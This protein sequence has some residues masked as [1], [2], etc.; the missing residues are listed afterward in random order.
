M[1]PKRVRVAGSSARQNIFLSPICAE[2]FKLI[3]EK[4]V[5][6]ERSINFPDITFLPEMEATARHY[7]WMDFNSLIGDCNISWVREFY[8]NAVAYS[9]EDFTSTVRGVR[10]SYTPAVIDAALGFTPT[11]HCWAHQ[12]RYRAHTEED[13]DQ[14]L[15]TLA[16]PGIDW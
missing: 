2:H 16:L 8:A 7:S 14:M 10:V 11:E 12:W 1:A 15:H 5:I 6:Q 9:E 13:F 4:N 3:E